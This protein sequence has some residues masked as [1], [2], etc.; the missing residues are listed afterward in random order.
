MEPTLSKIMAAL[1]KAPGYGLLKRGISIRMLFPCEAPVKAKARE[2]CSAEE[3]GLLQS[4]EILLG[5]LLLNNDI[6]SWL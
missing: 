6:L 1:F 2:E 5:K 3:L 4:K